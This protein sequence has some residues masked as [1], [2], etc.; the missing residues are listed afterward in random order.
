MV[1]YYKTE[2]LENK[3]STKIYRPDS[4][5]WVSNLDSIQRGIYLCRRD[6][7]VLAVQLWTLPVG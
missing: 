1:S 2:L 6:S 4:T 3:V 7:V 5:K